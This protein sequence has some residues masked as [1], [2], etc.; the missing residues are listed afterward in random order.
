[1]TDPGRE[2]S[3]EQD[4]SEEDR[5]LLEHMRQTARR[6]DAVE[7]DEDRPE[8]GEAIQDDTTLGPGPDQPDTGR[9]E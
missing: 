6:K 9:S 1:M 7:P 4:L 8:V 5:R 3:G 2:V